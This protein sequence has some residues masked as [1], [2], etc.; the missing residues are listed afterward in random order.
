MFR[1][2]RSSHGTCSTTVVVVDDVVESPLAHRIEFPVAVDAGHL[3][4]VAFCE[5]DRER[6]RS[7]A[8]AVDERVARAEGVH[9]G[10][11]GPL[12]A[13][14]VEHV[15][16]E[17]DGGGVDEGVEGAAVGEVVAHPAEARRLDH[18]V[19]GGGEGGHVE[20]PHPFDDAAGQDAY[21]VDPL[22]AAFVEKHEHLWEKV[23]VYDVMAAV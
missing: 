16:G 3:G 19:E 13:G 17:A 1:R 12:H 6:A 22:H 20:K 23:V 15:A 10:V 4:A 21:Q 2:S 5:L 18:L 7:A 11:Q 14:G 9:D 8:R